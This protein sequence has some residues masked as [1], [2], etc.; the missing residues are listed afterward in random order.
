MGQISLSGIWEGQIGPTEEVDKP[1]I[2]HSGENF[3]HWK[4]D[5]VDVW[6]KF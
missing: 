4:L 6:S 2:Q 3:G 1:E 5:K